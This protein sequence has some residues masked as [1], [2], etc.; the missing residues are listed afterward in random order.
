MNL[1]STSMQ[2]V[3]AKDGTRLAYTDVGQG[4]PV[5]LIHGFPDNMEVW[6]NQVPALLEG[7]YRVICM[8]TRGCGESEAPAAVKAYHHDFL[9]DDVR[10]VLDHLGL[11]TVRLVGHDWGAVIGWMFCLAH[12]ERVSRYLAVSVG[13][14][15][16]YAQAGLEQKLR[17]WYA[18]FFQ[19]R[20]LSEWMI[21]AFNWRML[22]SFSGNPLEFPAWKAALGRPGRL[23]AAINYYRANMWDMLFKRWCRVSVPVEGVWGS[24]DRFLTELQMQ[25]S[26][27]HVQ[28]PWHYTVLQGG[29]WIQLEQAVAFNQTLLQWL[30]KN[31]NGDSHEN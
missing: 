28:G 1:R 3:Q 10:V 31:I 7:G 18:A 21:K 22:R 19:L 16:A 9:V 23:T 15:R 20:G 26:A 13:H 25:H 5:F 17:G 12:P 27:Q 29:H 24:Q 11:K 2:Y 30:G 14:P 8:D 6:R 4:E